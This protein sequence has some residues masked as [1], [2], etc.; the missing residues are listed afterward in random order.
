MIAK[1][2][3]Q[4]RDVGR[5]EKKPS[6]DT[7]GSSLMA[8]HNMCPYDILPLEKKGCRPT[9]FAVWFGELRAC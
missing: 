9:S 6:F 2:K 5:E 7:K 8:Q 3:G 4:R 1:E